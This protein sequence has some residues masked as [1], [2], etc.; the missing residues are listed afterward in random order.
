MRRSSDKKHWDDFWAASQELDD[1]Y[2]TDDRILDNLQQYLSF[3]GLRVLEVGAGTGRDTDAIASRNATAYAL[4]YS[5]ES[6]SLMKKSLRNEVMI[7]C[8]DALR[9]PFRDES[10]DVVFHQGLLEHF[11]RPGDLLDEN[12]RVLKKNGILLVDVPQRYHYYTVLKHILI[13]CGRWFAGWEREFSA[14]ELRGL[15]EERGVQVLGTYGHNQFPPIWYRGL[16][17]LFLKIGLRLPMYPRGPRLVAGLGRLLRALAPA[18][19]HVNTA[20]I[21]GC[22]ARKK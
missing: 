14:R 2:G 15:L 3:D 11:R 13:A 1:V 7:A 18:G 6:L 19:L 22:I 5:E 21:V 17:R 12:V 4:D 9:L 8:G 20:M 16:R 10:F